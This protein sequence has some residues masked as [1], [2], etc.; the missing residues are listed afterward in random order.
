MKQLLL[1]QVKGNENIA[2]IIKFFRTS[3]W[4]NH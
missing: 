2:D 3:K 1:K 4:Y